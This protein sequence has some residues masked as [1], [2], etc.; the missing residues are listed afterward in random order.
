MHQVV[1]QDRT[2]PL[3]L[4]ELLHGL[5][6]VAEGPLHE[7]L[8]VLEVIQQHIPQGLLGQHLGVTQD[9]QPI[10]GS[11]QCHVQTPWVAQEAN[12]L[13]YIQSVSQPSTCHNMGCRTEG[14]AIKGHFDVLIRCLLT[15]G[16]SSCHPTQYETMMHATLE[17]SKHSRV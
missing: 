2:D 14:C 5:L 13:Q 12:A 15:C 4:G 6:Q 16:L 1:K 9:D 10:L 17:H 3:G 7:A 8:I 11:S